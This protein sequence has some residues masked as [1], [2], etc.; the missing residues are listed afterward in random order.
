MNPPPDTQSADL[1][2]PAR[3]DEARFRLY[4]PQTEKQADALE[5]AR[6]FVRLARIRYARPGWFGLAPKRKTGLRGGLYLV[7]PVGTGKTHLLASIYHALTTPETPGAEPIACAFTHSSDLFR[8]TLTPEAYAE[9]VASGAKV[10]CVD[11]IELDDPAQEVR[12]I[13]VLRALRD[14]RVTLAATSNADPDALIE[15]AQFGNERLARF[16]REEFERQYHVV[17][18][19]GE[20]F[21]QRLAKPGRAWVGPLAAA[22]AAM[23]EAYGAAPEPKRWLDFPDLLALTAN[24]ER[25]RLADSLASGD[26]LFL[27]GVAI[28]STDDALRLLRVMDDLYGRPDP[29]TLY[30]TSQTEPASWFDP[31]EHAGLARG[32]AEKFH[33]TVSRMTGLAEV[34]R[35]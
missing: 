3:F 24:T 1:A 21:R 13:G 4:R 33:R 22:R 6:T 28:S 7:G 5:K 14:R 34:Q 2:P 25:Q 27:D 18:V 26:A 8:S 29:P 9:R 32:I 30:F 19:P 17:L 16:I 31:R 10:L 11:E 12:L 20:D 15:G 35:V 23:R